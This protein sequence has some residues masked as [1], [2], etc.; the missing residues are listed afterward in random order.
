MPVP[1]GFPGISSLPG[2]GAPAPA[3]PQGPAGEFRNLL[4]N[5]IGRVEE[6]SQSADQSVEKFL[7][8]NGEELHQTALA[9]QRAE[10]SFE[11]FLQ[12]RNKVVQAYQEV[13]KMQ[14]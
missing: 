12:V 8:G 2:V 13:M 14:M 11:L 5:A 9:A 3:A 1:I 10:L 6:F 7:S 4:E